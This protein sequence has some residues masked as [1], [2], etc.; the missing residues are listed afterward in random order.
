MSSE[1]V[2]AEDVRIATARYARAGE[3]GRPISI[4]HQ[5]NDP[6]YS[7]KL[8]SVGDL[9]NWRT[10]NYPVKAS[11]LTYIFNGEV[12]ETGW[13][14][15]YHGETGMFLGNVSEDYTVFDQA[16]GIDFTEAVIGDEFLVE[17][18]G[19]LRSGQR[20]WIQA[21]FGDH[22]PVGKLGDGLGARFFVT[23]GHGGE[24]SVT[25]GAFTQRQDADGLNIVC[26]NTLAWADQGSHNIFR[27]I[28]N[29][30]L[31]KRIDLAK[32]RL[33]AMREGLGTL[34]EKAN[35]L[36]GTPITTELVEKVAGKL[37]WTLV[38]KVKAKATVKRDGDG[39]A[40]DKSEEWNLPDADIVTPATD[41]LSLVV[42]QTDRDVTIKAA[43]SQ[44]EIRAQER[45]N[46]IISLVMDNTLAE[47][48]CGV[49]ERLNAWALDQAI[50][51]YMDHQY[52]W[53]SRD[54]A[55]ESA[56]LGERAQVKAQ[57]FD[58]ILEETKAN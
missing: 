32:S 10:F 23:W 49:H 33:K 20:S 35:T 48:E 14:A 51:G 15:L 52:R 4:W 18:A 56:M 36:A 7:K 11:A 42:D 28:H 13:Y 21:A 54:A 2:R 1:I 39:V 58:L 22:F 57:M 26:A 47:M 5:L 46:N 53:R 40:L 55:M 41:I 43:A 30:N 8:Q 9:R 44:E 38:P 50:N 24:A 3:D 16:D 29:E 17:S 45:R 6:R 34:A 27:L 37:A 12:K 31:P 25:F 19:I